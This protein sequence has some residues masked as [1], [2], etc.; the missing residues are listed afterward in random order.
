MFGIIKGK[1]RGMSPPLRYLTHNVPEGFYIP[2]PLIKIS[3]RPPSQEACPTTTETTATAAIATAETE[4]VTTTIA[5]AVPTVATAPLARTAAPDLARALLNGTTAGACPAGNPPL[6][7][8]SPTP[9]RT[10]PQYRPK[11]RSTANCSWATLPPALLR[12]CS[13]N[14]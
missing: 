10:C 8:P 2:S 11:T 9:P 12:H 14:F 3:L 1:V 7:L 6:P 4:I 13:C 5:I